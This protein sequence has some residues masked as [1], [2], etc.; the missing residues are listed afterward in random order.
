MW[1]ALILAII[2]IAVHELG[3]IAAACAVGVRMGGMRVRRDGGFALYADADKASYIRAFAVYAGGAAA[4]IAAAILFCTHAQ[5]AA[6]N[7]GAAAFNL[8][9]LP[10]SDGTMIIY[11]LTAWLTDS[12]DLAYR[13]SH[14]VTDLSLA[15]FWIAAVYISMTG[16]GGAMPLIF[17][18]GLL[19]NRLGEG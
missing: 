4:N 12:P 8:L 10:A 1:L 2:A 5:F 14:T 7:L 19:V 9:P 6:Y 16:R 13:V 3:H 18:V 15:V 11:T 17:A